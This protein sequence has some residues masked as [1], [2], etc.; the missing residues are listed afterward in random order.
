MKDQILQ[1]KIRKP[2]KFEVTMTEKHQFQNLVK[3]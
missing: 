2:N 1:K 3:D